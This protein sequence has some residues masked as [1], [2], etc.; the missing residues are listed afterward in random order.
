M[1]DHHTHRSWVTVRRVAGWVLVLA[2]LVWVPFVV[3]RIVDLDGLG[4]WAVAP[5]A[6]SLYALAGTAGV[7]VVAALARRPTAAVLAAVGV[8]ALGVLLSERVTK[9]EQPAATGSEVTVMMAN[10]RFGRAD[11]AHIVELVRRHSVDVLVFNELD[12]DALPGLRAAGLERELPFNQA[13]P[14]EGSAGV[15][16]F[17]RLQSQWDDDLLPPNRPWVPAK[18]QLP[19][20]S[21]LHVSAM[22]AAAPRPK[23]AGLFERDIL[24]ELPGPQV[25]GEP[26]IVVGDMNA[27]LDHRRLRTLLGRG[28]R[29]AAEEVGAGLEPTWSR[30][31]AALT[32]DH[33]LVPSG[34]AVKSVDV[35]P[36]PGSDHR[37]VIARLVLPG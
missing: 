15:G 24:A 6:F 3:T 27:T 28:Y 25:A 26:T 9:D 29:D 18:V 14:G 4:W 23:S 37:A 12:K 5:Q 22:H 11:P 7:L 21:A 34:V 19:S 13:V 17:S 33:I 8:F 16:A 31:L 20:G 1:A 2:A 32:I 30:G 35:A 10:L 36:L